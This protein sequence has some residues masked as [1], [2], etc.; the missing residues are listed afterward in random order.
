SGEELDARTLTGGVVKFRRVKLSFGPEKQLNFQIAIFEP[1]SHD[2]PVPVIVHPS[3][4]ATPGTAPPPPPP[5][6]RPVT[7]QMAERRK[8]AERMVDPEEVAKAYAA[9]LSRG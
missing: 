6:T 4:Y 9:A 8:I 5:S 1:A 3:F 7:T 2:G